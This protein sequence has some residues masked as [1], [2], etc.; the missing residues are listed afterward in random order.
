MLAFLIWLVLLVVAWPLAL[1]ALI[2]Y[3][4]VWLIALPLRIVGISLKG[5]LDLVQGGDRPARQSSSRATR[6]PISIATTSRKRQCRIPSL[7]PLSSD[8]LS[9]GFA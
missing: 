5:L 7:G 6:R 4:F 3:P 9:H 8:R 2:L 1:L